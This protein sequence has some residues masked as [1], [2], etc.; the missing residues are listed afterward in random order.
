MTREVRLMQGTITHNEATATS[1]TTFGEGDKVNE[2]LQIPFELFARHK[3]PEH[4]QKNILTKFFD[5]HCRSV[6]A[7]HC[8]T[9]LRDR[10]E[11]VCQF[12]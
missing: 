1:P 5:R 6:L 4:T 11:F 8:C 9:E 7:D 3:I 2:G 10:S 12:P